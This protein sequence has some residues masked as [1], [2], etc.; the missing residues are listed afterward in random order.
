M[1]G[2]ML[3]SACETSPVTLFTTTQAVNIP[4]AQ[5]LGS[6]LDTSSGSDVAVAEQLAASSDAMVRF[7]P[8]LSEIL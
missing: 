7:G 8:V 5:D 3:D 2:Q 1:D 4:E 6:L